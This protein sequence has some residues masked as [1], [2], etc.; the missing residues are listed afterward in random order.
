MQKQQKHGMPDGRRSDFPRLL[1]SRFVK[2]TLPVLAA[3]WVAYGAYGTANASNKPA[4][5]NVSSPV[6]GVSVSKTESW[7]KASEQQ[8]P[9]FLFA[10]SD[11]VRLEQS[12]TAQRLLFQQE[13]DRLEVAT[14]LYVDGLFVG[15]LRD[16]Q[17]LQNLLRSLLENEKQNEKADDVSFAGNVELLTGL[18]ERSQIVTLNA[19]CALMKGYRTQPETYTVEAGDTLDTIIE[20]NDLT[21]VDLQNANP[22]LDLTSL[23]AGDVIQLEPAQKVLS[24]RTTQS[25]AKDESV[26]YT[27]VTKETD[28]LYE[29]ESKVETKG[30]NGVKNVVYAVTKVDGVEVSRQ[31]LSETLTVQPVQQVTLVGTRKREMEMAGVATGTFVWPTPTL[32][33]V[34]SGYGERW[35][36]N[37]FGL[38]ISGANASGEPIVAADGGTVLF[39]GSDDSG[40]GTYVVL[41]HGNGF[42]TYY[43]HMTQA[44]VQTGDKV[45]QGELIG[46]VGSTGDST[47]PHCHF[48][49]RKDG[50]H[51]DPTALVAADRAVVTPYLGQTLEEADSALLAQ[52]AVKRS[53]ES[54]AAFTQANQQAAA[55]D[56]AAAEKT[57]P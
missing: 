41:D 42:V 2:R 20:K 44:L 32:S 16:K 3:V 35:G 26:P 56:A 29:G 47:G 19:M 57:V 48:E 9:Q 22:G 50:E 43:G 49:V 21:A 7:Q 45:A 37:H 39:A 24:I 30:A 40:Y 33:M 12:S 23:H 15:A 25:V 36:S 1:H 18:Y 14:G 13:S 11:S 10:L 34:T 5:Q 28:S 31:A 8:D 38:D 4:P 55:D 17:A 54:I 46:L 53:D 52:A 27:S 51:I 6:K